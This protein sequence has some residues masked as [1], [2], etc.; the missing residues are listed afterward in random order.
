MFA[1]LGELSRLVATP[2]RQAGTA[3]VLDACEL[4]RQLLS[5]QEAYVVRAGD[6]QFIRMGSDEDPANYEIKQRG[7][8]V[9]WREAVCQA[10]RASSLRYLT[11]LLQPRIH[12]DDFDGRQSTQALARTSLQHLAAG[13]EAD[14]ARDQGLFRLRHDRG[15]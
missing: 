2:A 5:A 8:W 15:R 11:R 9:A 12:S 13:E 7:Y 10:F 14:A 6:P 4:V 3:T 1:I